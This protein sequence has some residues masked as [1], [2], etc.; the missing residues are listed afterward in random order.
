MEKLLL[1]L[2]SYLRDIKKIYFAVLFLLWSSIGLSQSITTNKTVTAN[3]TNCGIVNVK[4]DITGANPITRNS[5]VILAIDVS[6]SMGYTIPGD[7]KTS[8]D[9]AKDAALAFLTQAKVNPQNRIAIV[10]YST[11]ATLKIGLT[12][13]NAA[14]VAA[15]T[16]QI[17]TL[18]ATNSTNLYGGIV[19][20][21]TELET[22][23]RFDCSSA[24]LLFYLQ[25]V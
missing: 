5:D 24:R 4:V 23:G 20:S 22:N 12:Y 10:A 6:G 21:E 15:I 14:G 3:A 1:S 18:Q 2:S 7:F 19:R 16:A 17:N 13:L 25:M 8:M 11:T 9:Y